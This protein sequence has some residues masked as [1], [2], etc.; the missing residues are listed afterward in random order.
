MRLLGLHVHEHQSIPQ[1]EAW[2]VRN[3]DADQ[4]PQEL[5]GKIDTPCILTGDAELLR[6]TVTLLRMTEM[7]TQKKSSIGRRSSRIRAQHA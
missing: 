6:R 1:D 4:I 3:K 5:R 2:V 7:V